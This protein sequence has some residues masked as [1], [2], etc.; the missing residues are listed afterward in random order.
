MATRSKYVK[1]EQRAVI[2]AHV[3]GTKQISPSFVRV[4]IGG[5]DLRG[6]VP[7][8]F[9][10]W[11]RM[12]IPEA[13]QT[14]I[15]LPGSSGSLWFAQ[16]KLIPKDVRPVLRNYTV[17]EFRA[18]GGVFAGGPELDIDFAS[19]GDLGPASAWANSCA[20]G[21]RIGLLDEGLIYNPTPDA[22]WQLL[23]GD[24]S[25][26]PAIVGILRSVD[27]GVR[28]R[29]YVEIPHA[30]DIPDKQ[31]V[32]VR[33]GLDV[34]WL[35][36]E[37]ASAR[38]GELALATL[39]SAH[40]SDLPEGPFYAFVAG[41]SELATGVRRHL[42]NDRHVPKSDIAFTGYWRHGHAAY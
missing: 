22:R 33:D 21:D 26:L 3:L 27:P 12:F 39:R 29:A 11:F 40:L 18:T 42:V 17:R 36:R 28:V 14:S 24:E 25:A 30:G 23:V 19:H 20:P 41:E 7:M 4:T 15:R 16:F 2:S 31:D 32:P 13:G 10:Q 37:D 34:H 1:P 35:V 8:G 6:F 38:P 9:D 5:D